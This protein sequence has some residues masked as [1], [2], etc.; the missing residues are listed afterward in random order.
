MAEFYSIAV[1]G[2][3]YLVLEI[4]AACVITDAHVSVTDTTTVTIDWTTDLAATSQ[5]EYGLTT[6]YGSLTTADLSLVETHS[7]VLTSLTAST[8]YHY[9]VVSVANGRT[10]RTDDATFTTYG[11]AAPVISAVVV[12][13]TGAE[14]A[15]ITWTTDIVASSQ[16]EYGLTD[17]YG[18]WT[19][20]NEALV[21]SHSEQITGLTPD[22]LYHYRPISIASELTT[23]GD[24]DTFTTDASAAA[25]ISEVVVSA[26]DFNTAEIT[27]TTDI[28]ATS[29][30]QYGLTTA[31][32]SVTVLDLPLVTSHLQQLTGLTPATLYHFRVVSVANSQTTYGPD[33]TVTTDAAPYPV[34]SDVAVASSGATTADITWTTSLPADSR[35]EYGL[36]AAYGSYTTLDPVL[37]TS[38]HEQ[39]AGLTTSTLYHY[40]VISAYAGSTTYGEDGT[41]TTSADAIEPGATIIDAAWLAANGPAPYALSV[42]GRTYALQTDVTVDHRA[43]NITAPDVTLSLHGYTI[44]YDNAAG[45]GAANAGFETAGGSATVP[46]NWDVTNAG[47]GIRRSNLTYAFE[48]SW[49]FHF[50]QSTA[51]QTIVS[52]WFQVPASH[53]CIFHFARGEQIIGYAWSMFKLQV[54]HST[55]GVV[56]AFQSWDD[57]K[58]YYMSSATAGNY[59][60]ILTFVYEARTAWQA[61]TT[62]QIGDFVV[63]TVGNARQ[64]R[65]QSIGGVSTAN[66]GAVEPTWPTTLGGSVVDGAVTWTCDTYNVLFMGVDAPVVWP[67]VWQPNHAYPLD[68][69]PN[70]A[71]RIRPTVAN[72]YTYAAR[73]LNVAGGLSGATQPVWYTSAG[74]TRTDNNLVWLTRL[75]TGANVDMV[76]MTACSSDPGTVATDD[77]GVHVNTD[78][79]RATIKNTVATGGIVQG[80]TGGFNSHAI[81][82]YSNYT[83]ISNVIMST[84]GMESGCVYSRNSGHASILDCNIT[85]TGRWKFQRTTE[86]APITLRTTSSSLV[87]GCTID[88]GAGSGGGI[89]YGS[90][91]NTIDGN[92]I[93]TRCTLTNNHAIVQYGG[94]GS[95]VTH[96][97]ITCD[98]GQGILIDSGVFNVEVSDNL[99]TMLSIRPDRNAGPISFDGI[100]INDYW[101]SMH[102]VLVSGNT[103]I[104]YGN[105]SPITPMAQRMSGMMVVSGGA[106][107]VIEDNTITMISTGDPLITLEGLNPGG[108]S[109]MAARP[110]YRNNVISS[111]EYIIFFG[112]YATYHQ[113]ITLTDHTLIKGDNPKATFSTI[114]NTTPSGTTGN[115]YI[116]GVS[117]VGTVLQNGASLRNPS[118]TSSTI[119]YDYSSKYRLRVYVDD[120][121]GTPLAGATI[122]VL[123]GAVEVATGVTDA[124]GYSAAMELYDFDLHRTAAVDSAADF[125]EYNP[126]TIEVTYDAVMQDEVITLDEDTLVSFS[127]T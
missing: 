18:A 61:A 68:G 41:F 126:Y 74:S 27:W 113:N 84:K 116:Y 93:L 12:A 75:L 89:F 59:R 66:S 110:I 29:Q 6:A 7:E 9:R 4:P 1:S 23:N 2:S 87:R 32:G 22:T 105:S 54:E 78:G 106:N 3:L 98:P 69:C 53:W 14:T 10:T 125:T 97:T 49:H 46:A 43:F 96:N 35:V 36:T 64:Y 120:G 28:G 71:S 103:V 70:T 85:T 124:T 109:N 25:V 60:L 5:V 51:D 104:G 38:H 90:T 15:T 56:S 77:F 16:I 91:N 33:G 92:T 115:T 63:P 52:D 42:A 76:N 95:K 37:V 122:S 47:T 112:S 72:G 100:R 65:V 117:F 8:L 20:R 119:V 108:W 11:S 123:S 24:D 101:D 94:S 127:F 81:R 62:Y 107:V 58:A 17:G 26:Y 102:D 80:L 121:A 21:T 99:I 79:E 45:I 40:R 34:I 50:D 67:Y 114:R 88:A 19:V 55:L 86:L 48:G 73:R 39:I 83:T 31:Y 118:A 111:D 30:I 13:D 44:T 57:Y 82:L